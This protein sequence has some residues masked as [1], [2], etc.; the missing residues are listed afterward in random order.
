M[1]A[2]TQEKGKLSRN[3]R[4]VPDLFDFLFTR[5]LYRFYNSVRSCRNQAYPDCVAGYTFDNAT[6]AVLLYILHGFHRATLEDCLLSALKPFRSRVTKPRTNMTFW[7][8]QRLWQ[9]LLARSLKE[10]FVVNQTRKILARCGWPVTST[11]HH[12]CFHAVC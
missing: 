1:L 12:W 9:P 8:S 2:L 4:A 3:V 5:K 6:T 11:L 10:N 7:H